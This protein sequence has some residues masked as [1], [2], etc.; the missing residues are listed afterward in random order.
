MR[1]G[2][3]TPVPIPNIEAKP[4]WPVGQVYGNWTMEGSDLTEKAKKTL[5]NFAGGC[6][7]FTLIK[8]SPAGVQA[9]E[10]IFIS[11]ID[12]GRFLEE[13]GLFVCC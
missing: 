13:A 2:G 10:N 4:V 8:A 5:A 12:K 1:I 7:I 6:I 9:V 11:G 3:Q